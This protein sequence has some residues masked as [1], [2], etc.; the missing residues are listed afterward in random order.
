MSLITYW[1][2]KLKNLDWLDIGLIKVSVAG[3]VLM[4]AKLWTPLLSLEWYWYG[5]IFLLAGI[6]PIYKA[7]LK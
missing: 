1:N 5:L 2:K 4:V 6:K 3:F 7:Y